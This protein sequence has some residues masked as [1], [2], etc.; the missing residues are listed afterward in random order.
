MKLILYKMADTSTLI[1]MNCEF[2]G[3]KNTITC[4]PKIFPLVALDS[5]YFVNENLHNMISLR[6][7]FELNIH[8][9]NRFMR[10]DKD[11]L[12]YIIKEH[13]YIVKCLNEI[14]NLNS[15]EIDQDSI[16]K[17]VYEFTDF[18]S[19]SLVKNIV[20]I[21]KEELK[22]INIVIEKGRNLVDLTQAML[23]DIKPNNT[24][25]L[26]SDSDK[27]LDK[28]LHILEKFNIYWFK[29]SDFRYIKKTA[30][31]CESIDIT[32]DIIEKGQLKQ[33]YIDWFPPIKEYT[34]SVPSLETTLDTIDQIP[35]DCLSY[36][37]YY[38]TPEQVDIAMNGLH[39]VN[40]IVSM[41]VFC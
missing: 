32:T 21:D 23:N 31:A 6:D 13:Y 4:T 1:Q 38:T 24:Y 5:E 41:G 3:E 27:D 7:A 15:S 14:S 10:R 8:C 34:T 17:N 36:M 19:K 22:I 39:S 33:Y 2:G 16:D 35:L 30:Y 40:Y 26:D 18:C 12:K 25:N 29:K 20:E 28:S 9:V 11:F 37:F